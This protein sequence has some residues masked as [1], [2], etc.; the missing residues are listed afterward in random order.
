VPPLAVTLDLRLA[1]GNLELPVLPG[2]ATRILELCGREDVDL[3]KLAD[4]VGGDPTLAAHFLRLSNTAVFAARARIVS[5]RHAVTRLGTRTVRQLVL[6]ITC[7]SRAFT[8]RGHETMGR[9]MLEHAV[10]TAVFAQEVARARGGCID[11]AFMCGL[12]H[13]IGS[14]VVLQ[15]I[16]DLESETG[17]AFDENTV[18]QNINRLHEGV[19]FQIAS[20]WST[21]PVVCESIASHHRI[22][23]PVDRSP[24]ALSVAT[25]QLAEAMAE[26]FA[27][28]MLLAHPA[29]ALLDLEVEDVEGLEKAREKA[30]EIIESLP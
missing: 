6:L 21:S 25:I 13:D 5:L 23:S 3:G 10:T 7:H 29:V 11:E 16:S 2:A 9:E 19:G 28:D 24:T 30:A 26:G 18:M 12:L 4:V 15:I 1:A 14:P 22:L 8:V 17:V 20:A 27:T